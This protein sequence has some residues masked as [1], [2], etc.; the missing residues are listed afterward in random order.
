MAG[1]SMP[2]LPTIA[3]PGFLESAANMK[4]VNAAG[5]NVKT[6]TNNTGEYIV[7]GDGGTLSVNLTKHTGSYIVRYIDPRSGAA[8]GNEQTMQGGKIA[9]LESGSSGDVV[10]WITGKK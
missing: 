3:Y 9:K 10:A 5:S 4:P 7:Y 8:I 1:G 6:L 2:V